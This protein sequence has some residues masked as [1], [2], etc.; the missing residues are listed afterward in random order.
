MAHNYEL[1]SLH[2]YFRVCSRDFKLLIQQAC[3]CNH[4]LLYCLVS[5]IACLLACLFEALRLLLNDTFHELNFEDLLD[6]YCICIV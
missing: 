6:Y 5:L 2:S 1:A 4:A 3:S